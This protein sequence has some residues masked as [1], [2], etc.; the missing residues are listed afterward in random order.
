MANE[1]QPVRMGKAWSLEEELR[2]LESVQRKK[3][4]K[5][6][7]LEH[8]RTAGGIRG[9]LRK[10]AVEDYLTQ[11]HSLDE[12]TTKTGLTSDEIMDAVGRHTR[13]MEIRQHRAERLDSPPTNILEALVQI[14]DTLKLILTKL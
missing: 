14:N 13:K 7:A 1:T 11:T 5:T 6:I 12:I 10:I 2:V 3:D 9:R 8:E 4:I